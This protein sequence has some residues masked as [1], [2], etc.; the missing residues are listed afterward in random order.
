MAT[1][2]HAS[3]RYQALDK[4]FSNFGRKF[5]MEDLIEACNQAIFDFTGSD[6]GVKRRQVFDD[7]L[8]MESEQGWSIPLERHKD[9]KR[10]FYRYADKKFSINSQP[11]NVH[12]VDQIKSALE[13]LSRFKGLPNFEWVTELNVRLQ[14]SV[15]TQ[16]APHAVS[17]QENPYLRG[18]EHF[19]Q[20]YKAIIDQ[21]VLEITYQSFK[22]EE[23][24]KY[25]I[26][27]YHLKQ[28]N[29]RW[30]LFGL[31]AELNRIS[32]LPLDRIIAVEEKGGDYI[33]STIDF[34]EYFED[35]V[36]VTV[37]EDK[38]VEQII[39]KVSANLWP[40]IESKPLHESQAVIERAETH[41]LI[42]IKV[43]LNYE[44]VSLLLSYGE[45]MLVL[46]P[47]SLKENLLGKVSAM[48]D[49]LNA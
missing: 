21:R 41:V 37:H 24:V 46:E 25:V 6:N 9:G 23:S 3:I 43:Q 11:L 49:G 45:E 13:V 27:P 39:L 20:L 1:N 29:N 32:N 34:S 38:P 15:R 40:Y 22:Q 36:G 30:F 19:A 31:N 7:I 17:F 44:L 8:Y 42:R 14:T 48:R 28:Y 5:F 16:D 18:I 35:V 26:H 4:C 33:E 2:K 12:E 10:V 47:V